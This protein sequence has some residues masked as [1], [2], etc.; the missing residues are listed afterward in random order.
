MHSQDWSVESGLAVMLDEVETVEDSIPSSDVEVLGV[1]LIEL[2]GATVRI[3]VDDRDEVAQS[4]CRA[5]WRL[6][7]SKSLST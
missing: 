4:Y 1:G 6:C 2:L 3:G 5:A 7:Y